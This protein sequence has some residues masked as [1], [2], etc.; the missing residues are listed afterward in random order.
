M[1]SLRKTK[2]QQSEERREF[3]VPHTLVII[4]FILAIM[5]VATWVFP[6]G[7]YDRV[8]NDLGRTVVVDGSFK[9]IEQSPQG[10]FAL[11][12]VGTLYMFVYM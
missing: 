7:S 5:A 4:S 3:K 2:V 9:Y 11:L 10:L 6:A 1:L 8:V 12:L